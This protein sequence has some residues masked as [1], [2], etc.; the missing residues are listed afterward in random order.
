MAR[1]RFSDHAHYR[2]GRDRR[3]NA[4]DFARGFCA[5]GNEGISGNEAITNNKDLARAETCGDE[6]TDAVAGEVACI[7]G[8]IRQ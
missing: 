7:K 8:S 1:N 3:T 4:E 2:S 6:E 5:A